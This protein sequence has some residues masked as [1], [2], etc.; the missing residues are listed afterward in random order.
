MG[1][2]AIGA[3]MLLSGCLG[4]SAQGLS[5]LQFEVA[6]IREAKAARGGIKPADA[7][8]GMLSRARMCC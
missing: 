3:G 4:V 2:L 7:A 6:T 1:G 8:M 5:Q